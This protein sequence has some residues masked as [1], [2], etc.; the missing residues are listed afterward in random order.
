MMFG[1]VVRMLRHDAHMSLRQLAEQARIDFTY[2]SKIE[3]GT[4][5]PPSEEVIARMAYAL[6]RRPEELLMLAP[7]I[8]QAKLRKATEHDP[9]I[10]YL[11]HMLMSGNLTSEQI[12]KMFAVVAPRK[13]THDVL[14]EVLAKMRDSAG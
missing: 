14:G 13:V 10:G 1:E 4:V 9:R 12:D 2:L 6:N 11:M 5:L 3:S 7:K 8:S